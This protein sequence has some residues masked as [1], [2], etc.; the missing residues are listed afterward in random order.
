M[1]AGKLLYAFYN[2]LFHQLTTFLPQNQQLFLFDLTHFLFLFLFFRSD[3]HIRSNMQA[4]ST[5]QTDSRSWMGVV[6]S[7]LVLLIHINSGDFFENFFVEI[8]D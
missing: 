3:I 4:I 8:W 2:F 6:G 5:M 1:S 7:M